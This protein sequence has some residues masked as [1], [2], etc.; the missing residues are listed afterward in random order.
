MFYSGAK[1]FTIANAYRTYD[2]KSAM[3]L[4]D[5]LMAQYDLPEEAAG[6]PAPRAAR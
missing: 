2:W 4:V 5:G 3:A 6:D 1:H